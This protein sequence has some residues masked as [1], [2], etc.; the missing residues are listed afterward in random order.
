MRA[1]IGCGEADPLRDP[2]RDPDRPVGPGG[3][4]AVDVTGA[5]E[6]IDRL[7][8]LRREHGPLVREG[9]AGRLRVAVDRDHLQVVARPGGLE[10]AELGGAGA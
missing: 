8:V 9:E 7:L 6:A 10:Q 5:R 1:S 4:D 3:D 2:R